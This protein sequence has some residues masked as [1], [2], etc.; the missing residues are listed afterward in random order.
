[1]TTENTDE[2]LLFAVLVTE[3]GFATPEQVAT[4]VK[5]S[6]TSRKKNLADQL[7]ADGSI[8][9][10]QKAVI[11]RLVQKAL[12]D[13]MGTVA[14]DIESI[15]V[16]VSDNLDDTIGTVTPEQ[17]GR[18][19]VRNVHGRG[20]QAKV[21]RI[22]DEHIGRDVALKELLP[23][24]GPEGEATSPWASPQSIPGVVRFLREARVTGQLEHPNIVPVYEVGRRLDGTFYYTMRMVRGQT[25]AQKLEECKDL[26]ERM[27]LLG[28]FWDMCNAIAYAHSRGVV[29]RDI[30]PSN[31]MVGE[32]GET[33]LL[34][35]GIAK[36]KGKQ[37]I[38]ARDIAKELK[39]LHG[40]DIEKTT[41]GSA[42]G[43]PS[44]MSPEQAR[45]EIDLI[46]ERSDIWGLGSVLYEILTGRPPFTGKQRVE[47][48]LKAGRKRVSPVLEQNPDASA[49]LAAIAQK[50]LRRNKQNRY[51]SA[52]D[53]SK[54]VGAYMTG[55]KVTAYD[56]SSWELLKR[57]ALK[58]KVA[59]GAVGLVLAVIIGALIFVSVSYR[60]ETIAR[61]NESQAREL[62]ETAQAKEHAERL[63]ANHHLAQAYAEKADRLMADKRFLS[64]D[65]FAAASLFHNPSHPKSPF[66]SAGFNQLFPNSHD[67]RVEAASQIYRTSFQ[68]RASLTK[69]LRASEVLTR[70]HFAPDDATF[71]AGR[72]DGNINIWHM[73]SDKALVLKGHTDRVYNISYS[74][75]AK[76]L[77]SA[78]HDKTI[79]L[80]NV[81]NG[82][83]LYSV[84]AHS[85]PVLG[86][87][88]S[89][90]GRF[91]A[92]ASADSTI[93]I[94]KP[95]NKKPEQTI[96]GH[97]GKVNCL[98][99]SPNG[100]LIASAGDD[101]TVRLWQ[102][103]KGTQ[104][105][106]FEGHT[107]SVNYVVF[108]PDGKILASA[109]ND[110]KIYLWNVAT[111][112]LS[113]TLLG[114]KDGILSVAFSADG[115]LLASAS[116]DRTVRIWNVKTGQLLLTFGHQAFVYGVAFAHKS[117]QLVS[118]GYDKIA[119][120]WNL[121]TSR[122]LISLRGHKGTVYAV[123]YSSDGSLLASA[124][125]D[126]TI[127]IWDP[128]T[129]R[130]KAV[131]R[132]HKDII[133]D[134]AL[135]PDATR[136]ASACRDKTI[137]IWD[138]RKRK[139]TNVLKGHKDSVYGVA[140]SPDGELLASSSTDRTAIIWDVETGKQLLTLKGHK[141][142]VDKVAFSP[143][144]KIL[145]TAG[146][147]K[148]VRLWDPRS[149]EQL[150]VLGGHTDWISGVAFS[151]S[152]TKL[153][154]S[155]KDG[156]AIVWDPTNGRELG[157][158]V[159]HE[160]W[161]N[162]V[163]FSPDESLLATAS[164]DL[165]VRLWSL[166]SSK[167]LLKIPATSEVVAI[168]FSPDG[169][170]IA[171]GDGDD[172]KL[173]PIDFSSLDVEPQKLLDSAEKSAG[174][175]LDGFDLKIFAGQD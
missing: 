128:K 36:V 124:G 162:A 140:F 111:R 23:E 143:N 75:D 137:R 155:S 52:K 15:R 118:V 125:W 169:S 88:F 62:A 32:F 129:G 80:W 65:I 130:L 110:Q 121:G 119:K 168:E 27:K 89:P 132:G 154:S 60:A 61:K 54:D 157:R 16:G 146:Y 73:N 145:A 159:G 104:E 93:R 81:A 79:K 11:S 59:F 49:E 63:V 105:H 166:E 96:K 85:E 4:A 14:E 108:S 46:D 100:K 19:S 114:N 18:Y 64:T 136:L 173:Y 164:D 69:I 26:P 147:D 29:H 87:D 94:W 7:E 24:P 98:A 152:G 134:L 144:S 160:Q 156:L 167:P 102:L 2:Q 8:T 139:V 135:S 113:K 117:P 37:D 22:F 175:K 56:Y 41:A 171:I 17:P 1:L 120:V 72:T 68:L 20:G 74:P 103:P 131:L 142:E 92:S 97:N 133:D 70:V 122:K 165:T 10:Q 35:W 83:L 39:L 43:T 30:K 170:I 148:T 3:R 86:V 91:F 141:S 151:K 153:A 31:V 107:G 9:D 6:L 150:R 99:Y 34:D 138:L 95:R 58:H 50:A 158:F 84:R 57:Y 71:C 45:G 40:D 77:I 28:A 21:W 53:F 82:K 78:G 13:Q 112:K 109:G 12:S 101:K 161:V 5:A 55:E 149:G 115:S 90:D 172:V 123:T 25:L 66:Y 51:Q 106:S 126:K 174:M 127:R 67:L 33:V 38:G 76:H 47:I 163:R 42:M 48:L 44:Y 116:Y